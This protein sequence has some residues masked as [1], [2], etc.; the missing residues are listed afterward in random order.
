MAGI[1][2]AAFLSLPA[3]AAP[4]DKA[5]VALRAAME[6]ETVEGDVK[7]AI[8]Q[9]KKLAQ[10]G[11]KSVAA[12]ALVRLGEC[13]EKQGNAEARKTYEQVLSKFGDQKEAVAQARARLAALGGLGAGMTYRRV[14]SGPKTDLYGTVSSDGR[15]LSYVDWETGDLALH[16]IVANADRRLTDAGPWTSASE[17]AQESAI[18]RDGKQVAYA[19]YNTK[20]RFELRVLDLQVSGFPTPRQL[21]RSEDIRWIAPYD[22]SPDGKWL[23]VGLEQNDRSAQIGLLSPRRPDHALA[24]QPLSAQPR[25][26]R[27]LVPQVDR[28]RR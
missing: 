13:Y 23:A 11:N 17:Y 12:R 20:R 24:V 16:D 7:A 19:W 18:S 1:G 6:K 14:W 25:Q 28:L 9:Y 10:N 22:W 2:L 26:A 15:Y 4:Q 8:E 21:F 5:E 3:A 27:G